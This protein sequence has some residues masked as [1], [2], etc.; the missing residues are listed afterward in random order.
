MIFFFFASSMR[1]LLRNS[2]KISKFLRIVHLE[3][4]EKS[5]FRLNLY[6]YDYAQREIEK[7]KES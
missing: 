5:P 2:V 7:S 1:L 4:K 6:K 3:E